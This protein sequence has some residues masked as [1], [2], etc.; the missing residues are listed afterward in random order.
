MN[1]TK[2]AVPTVSSD[3]IVQAA[4][5]VAAHAK[6]RFLQGFADEAAELASRAASIIRVVDTAAAAAFEALA[7]K[8]DSHAQPG[9]APKS[10]PPAA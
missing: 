7:V 1:E 4:N 3:E 8:F 6:S 9:P 5:G 10:A 2:V